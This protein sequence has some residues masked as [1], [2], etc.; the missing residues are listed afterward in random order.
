M[1]MGQ[2]PLRARTPTRNFPLVAQLRQRG[3][4]AII[5]RAPSAR[6]QFCCGFAQRLP[7]SR[8]SVL[9]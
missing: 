2:A 7:S 1:S 8:K 6:E 4:F 9:N 5:R 3:T